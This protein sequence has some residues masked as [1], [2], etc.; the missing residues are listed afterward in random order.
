MSSGAFIPSFLGETFML[1]TPWSLGLLIA[2]CA[3]ILHAQTSAPYPP[4]TAKESE[5]G[6]KL[7][8]LSLTVRKQITKC[9][10]CGSV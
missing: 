10:P 7:A 3:P 6:K 2:I 5:L 4:F 8:E 9:G 1:R